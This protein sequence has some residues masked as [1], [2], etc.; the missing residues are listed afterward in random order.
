VLFRS[1]EAVPG[2]ERRLTSDRHDHRQQTSALCADETGERVMRRKIIAVALALTTGVA[3]LG[4][5]STASAHPAL[6]A[7]PWLFVAGLGGITAG[8]VAHDAAANQST[9][10]VTPAQPVEPAEVCH[11]ARERIGGAWHRVR[12]CE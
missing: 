10:V 5:P 7:I 2:A 8:V 4:M 6:V 9:T 3:A 11:V 12:V 1:A